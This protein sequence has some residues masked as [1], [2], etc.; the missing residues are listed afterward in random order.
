M[1]HAVSQLIEKKSRMLGKLEFHK[2]N[3]ETIENII[4]SIDISI[5]LFD[6][7]FEVEEIKSIR[8]TGKHSHFKGKEAHV[9]ILDTLRASDKPLSTHQ[10]TVEIMKKKFLDYENQKLKTKIQQIL[11][12]NLNRQAD[13]GLIEKIGNGFETKFL[14]WEIAN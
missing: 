4:N 10:V 7:D 5:K 13:K 8:F 6:E 3:I 12:N 11:L 9:M 2:K 14:Q 1:Q